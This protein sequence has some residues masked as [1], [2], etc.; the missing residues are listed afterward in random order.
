MR[1]GLQSSPSVEC[2]PSKSC[3]FVGHERIR[4]IRSHRLARW[5]ELHPCRKSMQSDQKQNFAGIRRFDSVSDGPSPAYF[6]RYQRNEGVTCARSRLGRG[7]FTGAISVGHH[8]AEVG[9]S[10]AAERIPQSAP[11]DVATSFAHA[12]KLMATQRGFLA[13]PAGAGIRLDRP[14]LKQIFRCRF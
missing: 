12:I 2:W 7:R 13:S 6:E 1:G 4:S 11:S 8:T 3:N 10:D 5:H 9:Q 14:L